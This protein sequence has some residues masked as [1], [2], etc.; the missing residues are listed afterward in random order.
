MWMDETRTTK[1]R[2]GRFH[3]IEIGKTFVKNS[4]GEDLNQSYQLCSEHIPPDHRLLCN[5]AAFGYSPPAHKFKKKN[6]KENTYSITDRHLGK[7]QKHF[8]FICEKCR[9]MG[10][11]EPWASI[12]L[13]PLESSLSAMTDN[14]HGVCFVFLE[15]RKQIK[16][17]KIEKWKLSSN[18]GSTG[19]QWAWKLID[20][21]NGSN[22]PFTPQHQYAYSPY[23]SL[24]IY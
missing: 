18:L 12:P 23:C 6:R 11:K 13:L 10:S 24:Y 5:L 8:R 14:T 20:E 2:G 1:Y 3:V 4:C 16:F 15:R 9:H 21:Q 22:E 19:S 7:I 17:L